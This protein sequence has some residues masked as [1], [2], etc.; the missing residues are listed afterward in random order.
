MKLVREGEATEFKKL[1]EAK[2]GEVFQFYFYPG[3][4]IDGWS[5]G[6]GTRIGKLLSFDDNA[7]YI[8]T[9]W[10]FSEKS[11]NAV[12]V[13]LFTGN[14]FLVEYTD[15]VKICPPDSNLVVSE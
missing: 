14:S 15:L 3:G 1:T 6:Q 9:D 13:D 7:I 5:P 2:K 12:V 11:R 4:V 8:L 10:V